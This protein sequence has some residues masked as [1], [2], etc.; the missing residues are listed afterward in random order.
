M[1]VFFSLLILGPRIA[2]I[3]WWIISPDRFSEIFDTWVIPALGVIFLPW[4]TLMYV[5][6]GWN[7]INGLEWFLLIFAFLVDLGSLGG[8]A[9]TNRDKIAGSKK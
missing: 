1:C 5:G 7:G 6:V 3:I 4:T 2:T 9:Y 8:G